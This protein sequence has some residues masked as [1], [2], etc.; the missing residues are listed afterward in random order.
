MYFVIG[1]ELKTLVS[2]NFL[3]FSK[4]FYTNKNNTSEDY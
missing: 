2:L 4:Y 3:N 1:A